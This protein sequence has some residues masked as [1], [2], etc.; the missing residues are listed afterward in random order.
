MQVPLKG[1][2]QPLCKGEI[3]LIYSTISVSMPTLKVVQNLHIMMLREV[4]VHQHLSCYIR[5]N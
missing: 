1:K 5:Y 2:H 4:K 3:L